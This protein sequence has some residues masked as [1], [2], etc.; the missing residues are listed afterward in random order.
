MKDTVDFHFSRY[1]EAVTQRMK[2]SLRAKCMDH[3]FHY[4][5]HRQ[6]QRWLA[7]HQRHSPSRHDSDCE[8]IYTE[9]FRRCAQEVS[10]PI[11]VVGLGCGGG[12]KDARLIRALRSSGKPLR[13]VAADVSQTLVTEA[14]EHVQESTDLRPNT[15]RGLV[16]DFMVA[17][18]LFGY[19]RKGAIKHEQQIFSFLG[20]IPNFQP[21]QA[22][23]VLTEWLQP[24][25]LL[26]LSANLAPGMD[27]EMGCQSI[28]SQ[29]DNMETR[30]WLV[31]VMEDLGLNVGMADL[32]FLIAEKEGVKRVECALIFPENC[33]II[34]NG[35]EFTYQQGESFRL[36][37]SNRF[38]AGQ[39]DKK[40]ERR[41]LQILDRYLTRSEEEGV[42]VMKK[43]S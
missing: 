11:Q 7:L 43:V 31:T 5:T 4:A 32:K 29:Y 18:N 20:M 17:E 25:D 39:L 38:Q 10:G 8:R 3:Q 24:G 16:A 28:L 35:E 36:F 42:W 13:Y 1:P 21:E 40:L 27:Y 15:M 34:Y 9:A 37:Y 19:W 23:E 33:R 26:V 41:G 22:L 30:H 14:R 6:A 12:R 2:E